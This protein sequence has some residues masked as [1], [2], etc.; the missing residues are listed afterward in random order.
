MK[1]KKIL[2]LNSQ[3]RRVY[4]RGKSEIK[5]LL[6]VYYFKNKLTY[7]RIGITTSKKIGN[8]PE[9]NR[10]KRVI[11]E[12]FR[13]LQQENLRL[14]NPQQGFDIVFVA[15]SKTTKVKMELVKETMEKALQKGQIL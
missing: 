12:A 4:K 2:N 15:R 11:K 6:V 8:A 13:L 5:P 10:A 14:Q 3:F 7:H 1:Q 9:R